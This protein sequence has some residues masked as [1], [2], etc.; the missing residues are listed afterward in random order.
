MIQS[1]V[2]K[3]RLVVYLTGFGGHEIMLIRH[4]K[5]SGSK[6]DFMIIYSL[7]SD[8]DLFLKE[9]HDVCNKV[10]KINSQRKYNYFDI[11]VIKNT[12]KLFNFKP[13]MISSGCLT[14]FFTYSIVIKIINSNVRIYV[15]MLISRDLRFKLMKLFNFKLLTIH[16]SIGDD[17]GFKFNLIENIGNS[18]FI[19]S[20]DKFVIAWIGRM[21]EHQ[22]NI[23]EL[24][25]I[26]SHLLILNKNIYFHLY[27]DG[28]EQITLKNNF[29]NEPRVVFFGWVNNENN[30][31]PFSTLLNT[32]NYEGV[33]LSI[34]DS[35][36]SGIPVIVKK[37]ASTF[38]KYNNLLTIYDDRDDCVNIVKSQLQ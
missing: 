16:N 20:K 37:S 25:Y 2:N 24:I 34:I 32:S 5:N 35:L 13:D 26:I 8:L 38:L 14:N 10:I 33:P 30:F 36:A 28:P 9:I 18:Q 7:E 11:S 23:S 27:G 31:E 22:K 15:P 19:L 12:Y 17:F 29:N 1:Y 6:Y 4:L 21:S 3:K